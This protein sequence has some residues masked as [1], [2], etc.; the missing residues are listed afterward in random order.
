[1]ALNFDKVADEGNAFIRSFARELG[2]PDDEM[3]AGRIVRSTLHGL[4][5][6]ISVEES[7]QMI[8][9]FPMFLKGVYVDGWSPSKRTKRIKHIEDFIDE[10]KRLDGRSADHDYPSYGEAERSI[11]LL[12]QTL[13]QYVSLGE[14]K[15]IET[16]LPKELKLMLRN[17]VMLI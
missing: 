12:F 8:A 10:I 1:M 4:R 16:M 2:I 15:D 17:T 9:Q 14:L 13:R 11:D 6:L 7:L 3:R 5:G